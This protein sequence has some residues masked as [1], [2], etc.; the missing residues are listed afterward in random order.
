MVLGVPVFA[1]IYT[2]IREFISKRLEEKG[3]SDMLKPTP[4]EQRRLDRK[5]AKR[6]RLE[7][8]LKRKHKNVPVEEEYEAESE[9]QQELIREAACEDETLY[10]DSV[11]ENEASCNAEA[12]HDEEESSDADKSDESSGKE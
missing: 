12:I 10:R 11:C 5:E 3:Y 4:T 9:D 8:R 2:L 7:E 1:V 6:Q